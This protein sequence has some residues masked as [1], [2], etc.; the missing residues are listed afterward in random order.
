M[1]FLTRMWRI[2]SMLVLRAQRG[3]WSGLQV[4]REELFV[5]IEMESDTGGGGNERFGINMADDGYEGGF[6]LR[7]LEL[8]ATRVKKVLDAGPRG[9]LRKLR[10]QHFIDFLEAG[11]GSVGVGFTSEDHE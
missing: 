5:R 1:G 7:I 11:V 10:V 4:V 6:V 9:P 8:V 3:V 2:V